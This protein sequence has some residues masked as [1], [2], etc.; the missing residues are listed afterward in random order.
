MSTCMSGLS[1][2]FKKD[3]TM[4][5][6]STTMK[7]S[8]MKPTD[9]M[10]EAPTE[11]MTER[12]RTMAPTVSA[13]DAPTVSAT[14]A[15]TVPATDA[16]TEPFYRMVMEGNNKCGTSPKVRSFKVPYSSV[17]SVGACAQTCS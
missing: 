6:E 17:G 8:T 9:P 1:D 13:T 2:K 15:P 4:M 10:T 12:P 14:D 3:T 16:Q 7:E 5:P 11:P